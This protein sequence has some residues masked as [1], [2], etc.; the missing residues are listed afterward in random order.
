MFSPLE[1]VLPLK[2]ALARS[3]SQKLL[4][5]SRPVPPI[6]RRGSRTQG[7]LSSV[8]KGPEATDGQSLGRPAVEGSEGLAK[9]VAVPEE[10]R[11]SLQHLRNSAE[12]KR[13][14]L[15][16]SL[17]QPPLKLPGSSDEGY[18]PLPCRPSHPDAQARAGAHAQRG[19][20]EQGSI[21]GPEDQTA[22]D[23][24]EHS[25]T[26]SAPS[27]AEKV[28]GKRSPA[29]QTM[30]ISFRLSGEQGSEAG[31]GDGMEAEEK[32]AQ[33]RSGKH[34]LESREQRDE[35]DQ[36]DPRT[37]G[38]D[39]TPATSQPAE[40][41]R[42]GH[43]TISKSAQEKVRQKR[44]E[45]VE[46]RKERELREQLRERLHEVNPHRTSAP[47]R[48][49]LSTR[50]LK[51]MGLS[52][53]V[54]S[55]ATSLR[56][57]INRPSLPSIPNMSQICNLTRNVSAH[58]LPDF[59]LDSR[60][61]GEDSDE[62][63]PLEMGLFARQEQGLTEALKLLANSDWEMKRRGLWNLRRLARL[64]PDALLTR[65]HAVT[66]AVTDEVANLRSKVARSA[67]LTL[68][69]L[70]SQLRR[71]MDQ[72]VEPVARILL[73]KAGDSN[74][75]I[76]EEAVR[77][78]SAVMQ[79]ASPA[80][81]LTAL[82]AGGSNHRNST[83]RKCAAEN[84]LVAVEH[85]GADRLLTGRREL[86]D[87]LVQSVV[88][89]SQDGNQETR[90]YGRK[91]LNILVFHAEFGGYQDRSILPPD[92]HCII[93]AIKQTGLQDA[94]LDLP[95]PKDGRPRVSSTHGCSPNAQEDVLTTARAG[96]DT[97]R[98]PRLG[99]PQ[100]SARSLEAVE[101]VRQ[102]NKMLTAKEF[103]ERMRGISL[104]L[105]LCETNPRFLT[106][107]IIDK[108]PVTPMLKSF[109]VSPTVLVLSVYR[110]KPQ[111]VE[112]HVLPVLWYLLGNM[113]GNG[114][115]RGGS[116]NMRAATARL[117]K[118]LHQEMGPGL[119]EYAQSQPTQVNTTLRGLTDKEH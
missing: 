85:V 114:V 62:D 8:H 23:A 80:R 109:S 55:H 57:R 4:N 13:R 58:S 18:R 59:P 10:V 84:L 79:S 20:V 46:R 29:S 54:S 64:H 116:G 66:L 53:T 86:V 87:Q 28:R 98:Q 96:L 75:F 89:F 99:P 107:N 102:L 110:R 42:L 101:Q 38:N 111:A 32:A 27:L 48:E 11:I 3:A 112:R 69:H 105:Q 25:L 47:D 70:F 44:R 45:E 68:G 77:A 92:V 67:I 51:E 95:S 34:T 6:E 49:S 60:E 91:V 16:A 9:P 100:A 19:P 63:E 52:S 72:E 56:R 39:S 15:G 37:E 73:H 74:E 115:I 40:F 117:V 2:P 35:V 33:F 24:A 50:E 36:M 1:T 65:L 82:I 106:S 21:S 30:V 7:D 31:D 113:T 71:S 93:S 17:C 26:Q 104:L 108:G 43:V 12:K 61:G 103:Q 90:F 22:Q 41:P 94:A 118:A 14:L 119:H 76:R 78:L 5:A 83:V 88:K 97:P 81:V